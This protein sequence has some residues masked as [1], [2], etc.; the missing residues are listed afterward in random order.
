M[1]RIA[2]QSVALIEWLGNRLVKTN[3]EMANRSRLPLDAKEHRRYR[4]E[5]DRAGLEIRKSFQVKGLRM[6]SAESIV[7]KRVALAE[8]SSKFEL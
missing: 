8:L 4:R 2:I 1:E 6:S 7:T 5:T 3:G